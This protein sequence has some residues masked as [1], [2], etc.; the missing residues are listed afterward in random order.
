LFKIDYPILMFFLCFL[1]LGSLLAHL[2]IRDRPIS[3]DCCSVHCEYDC[4]Q[5]G[6]DNYYHVCEPDEC[7]C[8][9]G[10]YQNPYG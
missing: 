7:L 2:A 10:S 1:A 9:N 5:L 8:L 4:E 6:Y 3:S